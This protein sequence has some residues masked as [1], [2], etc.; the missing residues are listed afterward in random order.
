MNTHITA[1]PID[2]KFGDYIS[3]GFDLL[4]NN[5]GAVFLGFLTTI[6]MSIIPFCGLLALGNYHKYLRKISK[7][8]NAAAGEIFDFKDFMPYFIL[9]LIILAAVFVMYIPIIIIIAI[10]GGV[11]EY[12][13]GGG[14]SFPFILFPLMAIM[15]F[16]LY[17]LLLK[18]F[19]IVP[20]ISLKGITDIKTAWNT[21]K[22]MTK[23]NLIMILLFSFVISFLS[24]IG[25][26]ACGI[27]VFFTLPLIYTC[28]HIAYED[29]LQQIEYD[30]IK[31]IGTQEL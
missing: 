20:L 21:S 11:N 8:Q 1:K 18:A 24:Q 23:G 25:I 27:G 9:Q 16:F 6:V 29:A 2:F 31:E 26:L 13:N 19:Y 12:Y 7:N 14:S 17:Y 4:K 22:V 5:Y 3:K 15:I 28:N 10:T 30:E